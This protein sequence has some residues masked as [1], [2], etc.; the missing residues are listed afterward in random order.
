MRFLRRSGDFLRNRREVWKVKI[1]YDSNHGESFPPFIGSAHF[2]FDR[3]VPLAHPHATTFVLPFDLCPL[4]AI[5]VLIDLPSLS[6]VVCAIP[7]LREVQYFK[8]CN[9]KPLNSWDL[10]FGKLWT[11]S[12]QFATF[13]RIFFS[14]KLK[15]ISRCHRQ[16]DFRFRT[17][18]RRNTAPSPLGPRREI[19]T[20]GR[21]DLVQAHTQGKVS[22]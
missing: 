1:E 3:F 7:P 17:G 12:K 20:K 14:V 13:F 16:S 22:L 11:V 10:N 5:R 9:I 2:A 21:P 6:V 18:Q 15:R 4:S 8:D 19:Y